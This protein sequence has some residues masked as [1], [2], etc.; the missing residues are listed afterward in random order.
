MILNKFSTRYKNEKITQDF[1]NTIIIKAE[2][3]Q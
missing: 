1:K 2:S 3:L